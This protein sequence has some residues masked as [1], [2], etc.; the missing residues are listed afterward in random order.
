MAMDDE[1]LD[2]KDSRTHDNLKAAFSSD[3]QGA[4]R[5]AFFATRAENEGLIELAQLF[6]GAAQGLST[7][8]QGHLGF[9]TQVGD[10]QTGASVLGCEGQLRSAIERESYGFETM[11][12]G[13]ART[14]REEG[15]DRVADW[16]EAMARAGRHQARALRRAL[17]ELQRGDLD[18]PG[19]AGED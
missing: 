14:A 3:A 4:C 11:Y 6:R 10:P 5:Y 12:S 18:E 17:D 15:F 8:A 7:H 9:L 1:V 13:F 2:L 19:G 16:F